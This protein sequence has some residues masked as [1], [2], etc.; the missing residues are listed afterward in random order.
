M[1]I[2]QIRKIN[3]IFNLQ[4]L[5]DEELMITRYVTVSSRKGFAWRQFR[6]KVFSLCDFEPNIKRHATNLLGAESN[7]ILVDKVDLKLFP[8]NPR[9]QG[10]I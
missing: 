1:A 2:A 9:F 4:E 5:A 7:T 6:R 3:I 8:N 10:P